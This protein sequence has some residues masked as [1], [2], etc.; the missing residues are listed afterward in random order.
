MKLRQA[1]WTHEYFGRP[2]VEEP[3]LVGTNLLCLLVVSLM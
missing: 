1:L 3:P 2:P